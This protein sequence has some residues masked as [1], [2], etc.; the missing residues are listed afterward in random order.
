[1]HVL[2]TKSQA[3]HVLY[4]KSQETTPLVDSW[5]DL[6]TDLATVDFGCIYCRHEIILLLPYL[7]DQ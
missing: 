5:L 7:L 2:Y 1:M 4:T 6:T 3:M